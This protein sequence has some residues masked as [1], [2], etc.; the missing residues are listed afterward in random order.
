[1]GSESIRSSPLASPMIPRLSKY[2]VCEESINESATE[3]NDAE[4][5]GEWGQNSTPTAA[6]DP[7][8][9]DAI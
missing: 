6:P 4:R 5:M 3:F 7:E 8:V 9:A 1:M 2:V